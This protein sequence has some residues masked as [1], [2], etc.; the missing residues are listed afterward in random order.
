MVNQSTARIVLRNYKRTFAVAMDVE[1]VKP[2]S[3]AQDT[4]DF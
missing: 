4:G 1:E 3:F 2:V